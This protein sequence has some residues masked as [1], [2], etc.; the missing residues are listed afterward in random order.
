MSHHAAT[1]RRGRLPFPRTRPAPG[2]ASAVVGVVG[3]TKPA[4]GCSRLLAEAAAG[5]G[6]VVCLLSSCEAAAHRAAGGRGD[7]VGTT[8]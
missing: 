6:H 2:L 5:A 3:Y 1:G 4:N 8:C 7:K